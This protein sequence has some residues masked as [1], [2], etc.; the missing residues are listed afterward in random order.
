MTKLEAI[1]KGKFEERKIENKIK[2]VKLALDSAKLN[3]K[4]QKDDNTINLD[5]ALESLKD[6]DVNATISKISDIL[7]NIEEANNGLKRIAEIETLLFG[8]A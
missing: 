3:F 5:S 2:R 8:E 1:L 4:S 6:S 7:D